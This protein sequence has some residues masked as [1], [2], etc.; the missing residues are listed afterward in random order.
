[1][2]GHRKTLQ[3]EFAGSTY[4]SIVE[5]YY[6]HWLTHLTSTNFSNGTAMMTMIAVKDPNPI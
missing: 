3:L 1:M 5:Y 6:E 2:V 4:L